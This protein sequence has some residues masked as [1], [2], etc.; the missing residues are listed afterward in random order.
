M[1]SLRSQGRVC[2][3]SP[4]SQELL[5][6]G[7]FSPVRLGAVSRSPACRDCSGASVG[8]IFRKLVSGVSSEKQ[9]WLPHTGPVKVSAQGGSWGSHPKGSLLLWALPACSCPRRVPSSWS[10]EVARAHQGQCHEGKGTRWSQTL[11]LGAG[12]AAS[13]VAVP[14]GEGA[15]RCGAPGSAGAGR[16]LPGIASTLRPTGHAN[17]SPSWD[18]N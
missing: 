13:H 8:F 16:G 10:R 1:R 5:K 2:R 15:A 14:A 9:L 4:L 7:D 12:G 18:F 6:W 3:F 11:G 17:L